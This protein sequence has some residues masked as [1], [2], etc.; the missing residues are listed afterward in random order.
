MKDTRTHRKQTNVS[1]N[2]K[3]IKDEEKNYDEK[4]NIQ[5]EALHLQQLV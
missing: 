5:I 3:E 1:M 4:N 2:E